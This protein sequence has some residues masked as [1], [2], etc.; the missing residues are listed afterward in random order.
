MAHN[1]QHPAVQLMLSKSGKVVIYARVAPGVLK[2][3][4]PQTE[5]L[6]DVTQTFGYEAEQISV[7]EDEGVSGKNAIPQRQGLQE[8]LNA[9]MQGNMHAILV[10]AEEKLFRDVEMGEISLFLKICTNHHVLLLTPHRVYDFQNAAHVAL[11]R[12]QCEQAN[13]SIHGAIGQAV[14]GKWQQAQKQ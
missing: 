5:Q 8:L 11:F 7:Y 14:A 10:T 4:K 9:V 13:Q 12:F 6:Y 2:P 1:N 3:Q